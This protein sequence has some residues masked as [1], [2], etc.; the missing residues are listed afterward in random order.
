MAG[1]TPVYA[2][3]YPTSTDSPAGHTQMQN[4]ATDVENKIVLVDAAITARPILGE[5]GF[6]EI[7]ADSATF[8]SATKVVLNLTTTFTG[9]AGAVYRVY[10]NFNW[11]CATASN[12]EAFAI[13][14]RLGGAGSVVNT[15][16]LIG[17]IGP[18]S[19]PDG[20]GFNTTFTSGKFT[21][22]SSG[23]HCVALVGWKPT[24]NT[25]ASGL[26][27]NGTF[28]NNRIWIDRIA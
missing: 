13:G 8:N 7:T 26:K 3:R 21:A 1:T 11:S 2:F 10:A 4:L 24:G 14:W 17:L 27:A 22:A 6:A 23:T 28:A 16:P 12:Q 18:R 9:I 20:T 5:V 19:H 15:D 25:G